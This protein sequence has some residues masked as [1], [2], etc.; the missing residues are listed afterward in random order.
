M[1]GEEQN[2][3][4][5]KT[6]GA[7]LIQIAILFGFAALSYLDSITT[8]DPFSN[9][10]NSAIAAYYF[11]FGGAGIWLA[12]EYSTGNVKSSKIALWSVLCL[13]LALYPITIST[14]SYISRFS[15]GYLFVLPAPILFFLSSIAVLVFT[16]G[17]DD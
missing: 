2:P 8:I 11:I 1:V 6:I 3:D 4:E 14:V 9:A 16:W 17:Y 10:G 7:M 13:I 5:K 15:F 12:G